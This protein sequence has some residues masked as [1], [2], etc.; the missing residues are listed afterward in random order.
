MWLFTSFL[1]AK[2]KFAKKKKKKLI[3]PARFIWFVIVSPNL[4][5]YSTAGP[6]YSMSEGKAHGLYIGN[7]AEHVPKGRE[8]G[9]KKLNIS[10]IISA[11]NMDAAY[12][13]QLK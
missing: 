10:L 3:V 12:I 9:R 4:V 11:P 7:N 2:Y 6:S 13:T 1:A 5:T 8:E